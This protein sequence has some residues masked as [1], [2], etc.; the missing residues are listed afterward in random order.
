LDACG[1]AHVLGY[2]WSKESSFPVKVGPDLTHNGVEDVFVA[3]VNVDG[4]DL[5]YCGYI[6]GSDRDL[7]GGIA[8][9]AL[10]KA[11][12]T[13]STESNGNTFPVSVGPVLTPKGGYEAFVSRINSMGTDLEY[14]GYIGG[15][16]ADAGEGVA[17]SPSGKAFVT[18]YT[19]SDESTFPVTVGPDLTFNSYS[20]YTDVFVAGVH[21]P[22]TAHTYTSSVIDPIVIHFTL[23][24]GVE[25]AN[26]DYYLLGSVTGTTP[27]FL[28]PGGLTMP[29]NWDAFTDLVL[30]FANTPR[31]Q[32]FYG[33]LD[34]L[35]R[36]QAKLDSLVPLDPRLAGTLIRFAYLVYYPFDF[37]SNP[38][39]FEIAP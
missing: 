30:Y 17:V 19:Y 6:G 9:D 26:R 4:T 36:G 35:G 24:A 1:R 33:T 22:L 27:G 8:V 14:C 7:P 21:I 13:G 10:N 20:G 25:N 38:V 5:E 32:N 28:L 15:S 16:G 29:L 11:Y 18:G 31:M 39:T 2:A 3:R 23:E 37:V 34:H 12:V